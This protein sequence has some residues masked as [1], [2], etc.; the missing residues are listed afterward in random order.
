M[1]ATGSSELIILG[2]NLQHL[3]VTKNK[4]NKEV[5]IID[6]N[7]NNSYKAKKNFTSFTPR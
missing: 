3:T 6:P 7:S 2:E 4:Q 5:K 1:V